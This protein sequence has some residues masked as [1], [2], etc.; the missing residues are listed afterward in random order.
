MVVT[1][2]PSEPMS[3]NSFLYIIQHL[4]VLLNMTSRII[5]VLMK[6]NA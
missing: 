6:K 1:M 4:F 2:E 5:L 3:F